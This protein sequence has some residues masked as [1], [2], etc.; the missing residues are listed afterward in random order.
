MG[1]RRPGV[2]DAPAS[3]AFVAEYRERPPQP[4]AVVIAAYNEEGGIGDVVAATPPSVCGLGTEVIVVVDGSVDRTASVARRAGALVWEVPVNGGQGTALRLGY[5]LARARGA[6]YIATLDGDGQYDP[7]ELER[8]V[9]PLV[10]GT[11]DLVS[12][13]RRLGTAH[14]T[15][16]VRGA[17]VV[18]FG[19]LITLL[20][21]TRI[22]DPA[23]G[24]RAMRAEVTERVPLEQPQYQASELLVGAILHGFRVAEVPTTMRQR[25]A[26]KT[27]KG[28]NLAYGARFARVIATTWW[29]D[30]HA[31]GRAA[32]G[33]AK[34]TSS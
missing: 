21:G 4:L 20:T 15:D 13:S 33:S 28:G 9:A 10:A 17:G 18:L 6:R 5:R 1:G 16:R 26:G 2:T 12:G 27:K 22:T 23:N 32:A 25:S 7:D 8:V 14:T 34:I 29:R 11:A 30:R 19:A 3:A 31:G 24:L